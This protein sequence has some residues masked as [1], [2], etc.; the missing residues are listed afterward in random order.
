MRIISQGGA[1]G[2]MIDFRINSLANKRTSGIDTDIA[3]R[4][5]TGSKMNGRQR[6]ID[7]YKNGDSLSRLYSPTIG[8]INAS[9]LNL[10]SQNINVHSNEILH[11]S[12]E[13]ANVIHPVNR[14]SKKAPFSF[15]SV[16]KYE[17][18][19]MDTENSG[20]L[21]TF[22]LE[23]QMTQA[24]PMYFYN[25][26]SFNYLIAEEQVNDATKN[27]IE[28]RKKSPLD[29]WG[30]YSIDGIVEFEV[31]LDGGETT[32]SSGFSIRNSKLSQHANG[33]KRL[34]MNTKGSQYVYNYCQPLV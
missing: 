29:Y 21:N 1:E 2:N 20:I 16:S 26:P 32:E 33:N 31:A 22:K 8:S 17:I 9:Y 23:G 14:V 19:I 28:Y 7:S 12:E 10:K 25:P 15:E 34:T 3:S 13:T 24:N 5:A 18:A 30:R 27:Q 6:E 11:E 4:L